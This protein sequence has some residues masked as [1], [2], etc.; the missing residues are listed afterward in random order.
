MTSTIPANRQQF[1]VY[2]TLA[3]II[4]LG[5]FVRLNDLHAWS[6]QEDKAFYDD[7]PLLTTV[8]GY[9]YLSLARDLMEGTYSTLDLKR[10]AP[11]GV[12]QSARP[13]LLSLIMAKTANTFSVSLEWVGVLLPPL[14]GVLLAIPVF[15][16]G[17]YF[18]GDPAGLTAATASML[19]P[20]YAAKTNLGSLDTDILNATLMASIVLGSL[21]FAQM[22]R[23][24]GFALMGG[25]FL[26]LMWW[27]DNAEH[28]I[29][30]LFFL[31]LVLMSLIAKDLALK[32]R[33]IIVMSGML[34]GVLA[35]LWSGKEIGWLFE[36]VFEDIYYIFLED[37]P[38]F[39]PGHAFSVSE[40]RTPSL[41][42][43]INWG[44]YWT[45]LF[46]VSA[47]GWLVALIK[48]P[49]PLALLLP[50]FIL[51]ALTLSAI[52]FEL[53]LSILLALGFGISCGFL[54]NQM[55]R[56][57]NQA[58]LFAVLLVAGA[59]L[60]P[61]YQM[62]IKRVVWP[63]MPPSLVKGLDE[64]QEVTPPESIIWSEWTLG[65][66]IHYWAERSTFGDGS[67]H[68]GERTVYINLPLYTTDHQL[69]AN[70]TRFIA[71]HGMQGPKTVY[72]LF[73]HDDEKG[74]AFLKAV[75]SRGEI[76]SVLDDYPL[77]RTDLT[78][79]LPNGDIKAFFFPELSRP[80]YLFLS[81]RNLFAIHYQRIFGNWTAGLPRRPVL[82][83]LY[84][85]GKDAKPML[86]DLDLL[87][88]DEKV[89]SLS[90]AALT[91][92]EAGH[93]VL[94]R[95]FERLPSAEFGQRVYRNLEDYQLDIAIDK[96]YGAL[97]S[98]S[99]AQSVFHQM[100]FYHKTEM[101]NAE[102]ILATQE[103]SLWQIW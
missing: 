3:G 76:E 88:T 37:T 101:A 9:Y 53:F 23:Y 26:I 47:I 28:A 21:M 49:R 99:L 59:L 17:R 83:Y 36:R 42:E 65:Y 39:W 68:R 6:V 70:F 38:D 64:V 71:A 67:L 81:A 102:E 57:S 46:V 100:Y 82:D 93:K 84:I 94:D 2:L 19:I 33:L 98:Q 18:G 52:R 91:E 77:S 96:R 10:N 31:S 7:K 13:P 87:K 86:E 72:T 40:Q 11:H 24:W 103:Y 35:Y 92:T 27:W 79:A 58:S 5:L 90:L 69:A 25:S 66:P 45:P 15:F 51:S 29:M 55:Q 48:Q 74:F 8:D 50:L 95:I 89:V 32:H 63:S 14:L 56:V 62:L 54:W 22:K 30:P 61:A 34:L 80:V 1:W 44:T 20:Y 41:Q 75:L 60:F 78:E 16:L 73:D 43:I 97:T 12:E 4:L 85:D